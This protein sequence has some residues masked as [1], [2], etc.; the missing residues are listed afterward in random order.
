MAPSDAGSRNEILSRIS[1]A[2][3]VSAERHADEPRQIFAPVGDLL[4]RFCEECTANLTELILTASEAASAKAIEKVLAELPEG[5]IYLQDSAQ[6]RHIAP[7]FSRPIGW[8]TAGAPSEASQATITLAEAFVAASGSILVSSSC[9][10]RGGSIVAPCHIVLGS[11]DQ[12][13]PDLEAALARAY[14]RGSVLRNSFVGLITG[15]SRTA[16]IEKII[17]MGAHGPRRLVVVLQRD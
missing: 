16:D 6:L 14:E 15:S 9:G 10:G 4:T 12:L 8:S 17:V 5:E 1:E 3:R 11:Y 13:V 2:V 7:S